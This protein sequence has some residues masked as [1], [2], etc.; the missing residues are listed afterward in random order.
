MSNEPRVLDEKIEPAELPKNVQRR[1]R[2]YC[3]FCLNVSH[4]S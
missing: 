3:I 2:F 4:F 1:D